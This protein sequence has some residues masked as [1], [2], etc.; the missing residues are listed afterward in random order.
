MR[1]VAPRKDAPFAN[2]TKFKVTLTNPM[3][4]MGT[5]VAGTVKGV[6]FVV[7]AELF[8]IRPASSVCGRRRDGSLQF[9]TG[10]VGF[11]R[12]VLPQ[13]H[14]RRRHSAVDH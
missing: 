2:Q 8:G 13:A 4:G 10:S 5:M 11:K 9:G 3:E 6:R 1:R 7:G 12:E 14:A